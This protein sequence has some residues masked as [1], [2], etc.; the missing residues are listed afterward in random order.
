[1][2]APHD[3][4]PRHPRRQ[5]PLRSAVLVLVT[6]VP[7]HLDLGSRGALAD[8]AGGGHSCIRLADGTVRCW[9][10]NQFGQVGD[11]STLDRPQPVQV[12]MEDGSPLAQV[13]S[14]DTGGAHTCART[15][16]GAA[17]CWGWNPQGSLGDGTT[18]SDIT[19][20][21]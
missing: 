7:L 19:P 3:R 1:M 21:E 8:T 15:D 12:L 17:W 9:G 18:K 10:W 14:V 6:I 2:S 11:G 4:G 13:T 5:W 20:S 16:D